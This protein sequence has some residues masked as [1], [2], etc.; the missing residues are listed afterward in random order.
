MNADEAESAVESGGF[1][2]SSSFSDK[3]VRRMFIRKVYLILMVQLL[4][5][6]GFIA[7]FVLNEDVKMFVWRNSWIYWM[8]YALFIVFFIFLV[9]CEKIRRSYPTN[10]IMLALFTLCLSYMAGTISSTYDTK[11]VLIAFGICAGVCLGVT[12]FSIQ[13]KFDFTTCGSVLFMCSLALF[14]FGFICIFT[15]NNI[16]QTVYAGLGALLFSAFLAFDTQLII[17][18]KRY[19]I[20]PEDYVFAALNLYIDMVYIFLFLLRLVGGS[21]NS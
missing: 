5:T 3:T 21:S 7:L 15:Y 14:L 17:G 18:G 10:V 1:E 13:T 20:S 4:C 12:I 6:M 19:E 8:S 9:C 11:S 2:S 16:L